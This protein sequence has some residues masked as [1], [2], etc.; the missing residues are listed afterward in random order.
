MNLEEIYI[1][2]YSMNQECFHVHSA[3]DMIQKNMKTIMNR[4]PIDYI[5]I[6]VF[7]TK[8]H[9]NEFVNLMR[10]MIKFAPIDT[11]IRKSL[12]GNKE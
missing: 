2:E 7:L 1:V 5:P 6:G 3:E 12:E 9:A 8:E 4:V 10:D 11:L